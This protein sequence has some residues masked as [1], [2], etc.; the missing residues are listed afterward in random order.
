MNIFEKRPS[1]ELKEIQDLRTECLEFF[2]WAAQKIQN[3]EKNAGKSSK[4]KE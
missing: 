2:N 3:I 4:N 1:D